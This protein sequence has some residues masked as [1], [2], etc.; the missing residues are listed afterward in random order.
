MLLDESINVLNGTIE[1]PPEKTVLIRAVSPP[2][3]PRGRRLTDWDAYPPRPVIIG[4]GRNP[5]FRIASR[6]SLLLSNLILTGGRSDGCGGAVVVVG[7][8]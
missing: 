6:G 1:I 5:L 3:A 8:G 4:D 2:S 7:D